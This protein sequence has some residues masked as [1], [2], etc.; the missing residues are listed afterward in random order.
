M[1]Y[2]SGLPNNNSG[3]DLAKLASGR[4]ALVYNPVGINWGPRTP[5]V[6]SSDNGQ[7][8]EEEIALEAGEG[9]CSYPAIVTQGEMAYMTYTWKRERIAF[10]QV[11][12]I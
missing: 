8:W 12:L 10:W 11:R 1:A 6:L 3:I 7:S 4:L 9:E 2:P 5:L